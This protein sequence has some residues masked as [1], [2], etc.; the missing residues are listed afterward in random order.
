M[1]NARSKTEKALRDIE[2]RI[3]SLYEQAEKEL[4]AKWLSFMRQQEPKIEK[5]YKQFV[6]AQISGSRKDIESAKAEY[7]RMMKKLTIGNERYKAL[8]NETTDKLAR[9][10]ESAL[11]YINDKM[12][13]IYLVNY[14]DFANNK[15][16]GYSFTLMNQETLD[17]LAK[18]DKA[19]IPQKYLDKYKDKAWNHKQINSQVFQGILQGE[20]ITDIAK[21]LGN[22]TGMNESASIRNARTMVTAA[23]NKGKQDS[24]EKAHEDGVLM[25]RKWIATLDE[26]TREAHAE[27]DGV[28]VEIDEPWENEYG[29]I[30]YPGDPAADPANT[31][32][33]RCT[34][35]TE[36]KGFKWRD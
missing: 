23:E 11:N 32:N 19:F 25:V 24:C 29:E 9:T 7:E 31:Y 30:M 17:N 33:C 18:K 5:A 1:S 35:I 6:D 4:N 16:K 36:I 2:K 26:R 14:N 27:L 34:F 15:I 20:S 13:E 10:N 21:R 22:V 3:S 28:E 12:S 8:V